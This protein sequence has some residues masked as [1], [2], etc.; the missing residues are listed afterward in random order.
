MRTLKPWFFGFAV[1]SGSLCG[2]GSD[3]EDG[4]AG[5]AGADALVQVTAV[6]AG[7]NCQ[8]GGTKVQF[9][10]DDN[11][12]EKLEEAEVEGT[13]YA[14]NG[15]PGEDGADGADGE[16]GEDGPSGQSALITAS[17]EPAGENCEHG[18][19]RIDQGLDA[20]ADG[21]L[22]EDEVLASSY[23][24]N[25]G[26][27]ATGAVGGSALVAVVAEPAGTQCAVGGIAIRHGWDDDADGALDNTEIEGT[28]YVC[29]GTDGVSGSD[30]LVNVLSEAVGTNCATGGVRVDFGAD[31]DDDGVL[32]TS[33]VEGTRYVCNGAAGSNGATS[34]VNVTAVPGDGA[35]CVDGGQKIEVGLDSNAD[36]SLAVSE[37][38][39]TQYVCNGADGAN[40]HHARIVMT[41][42]AP[43]AVCA[44][45]GT[46][47]EVGVDTDDNG[48]LSSEEVLQTETI[49]AGVDGADG[50]ASLVAIADEP[51]GTHCA[52]G[53]KA[54]NVGLDANGDGTLAIAEVADTQ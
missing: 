1:L 12:N 14:C 23:V 49:C 39:Q 9:G 5:P 42:V 13:N 11:G 7:T 25:G 18:G 51:A 36:N 38:L 35:T 4:A 26:D 40:G 6:A 48:E 20:N 8:F 27:G 47:I 16:N 31:D 17:E 34:L 50:I 53:G 2:C 24:C 3:G 32:D 30:G 19:Q 33:E 54:L 52:V 46:T 29:N 10:L 28:S 43:G 21:V 22:D 41:D 45:G 44:A 15:A 37:V